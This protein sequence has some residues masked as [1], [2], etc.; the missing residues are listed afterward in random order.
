MVERP[1]TELSIKWLDCRDQVFFNESAQPVVLNDY[2][3]TQGKI[4]RKQV[5]LKYS[6]NANSWSSLP[7][8]SGLDVGIRTYVLATY[9]N[10]LLWIGGYIRQEQ[11]PSRS[12]FAY[13]E[14]DSI[15]K[16]DSTIP[17]LP[18]EFQLSDLSASS[19]SGSS[20]LAVASEGHDNQIKLFVFNG[21]EWKIV[22]GPQ[23]QHRGCSSVDILLKNGIVYLLYHS[24]PS[25]L[26]SISLKSIIFNDSIEWIP[27]TPETIPQELTN[28]TVF[29]GY[30]T[31]F[32]KM[33]PRL[34]ILAFVPHSN[35]WIILGEIEFQPSYKPWL[36]IVGLSMS[37]GKLLMIGANPNK[38][39]HGHPMFDICELSVKGTYTK[40]NSISLI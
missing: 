28:L 11:V 25:C 14:T 12:V 40:I 35:K 4:D 1:L 13:D 38:L 30:P 16:K 31:V 22:E 29:D 15:W 23:R 8:P 39:E 24:H 5:P 10:R 36:S 34:S 3:Y 21:K 37:S 19:E 9:N 27:G 7:V 20:Y 17:D 33:T 32:T 6:I 26:Y 18:T 2:V